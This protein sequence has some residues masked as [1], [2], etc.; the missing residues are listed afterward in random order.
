[1]SYFKNWV[2]KYREQLN[3]LLQ[4][5]LFIL[6][7]IAT[8]LAGAEW[9]FGYSLYNTNVEYTWEM[10]CSGLPF[11]ISFLSILT[12]HE[13]GHYFVAKFYRVKTSLPYYIPL[14]PF[15][16]SLGTMGAIIRLRQRV[17]TNIQNFDIGIAGPLAGFV[18]AIG[19]LWYG[20]T[21][22][23]DASYI[24]SIHPEYAIYGSDFAKHVYENNPEAVMIKVG[25]NLLFYFFKHFVAD[26][27]SLPNSYEIMHYPLL[28]AG[29]L[30]LVFT[31]LN[32]LPIGQLDGGHVLYGL[33]GFKRHKT[34]ASIVYLLLLFYAG[35]G[36][37]TP[38]MPL[39]DLVLY[40]GLYVFFLYLCLQGLKLERQTTIM[41][42][43]LLFALQFLTSYLFPT[44]IGYPG[45]LLFAFF[46]GRMG[47][48]HPPSLIEIP[49]N[50]T[51]KILGWI[52]LIIFIASFTPAPL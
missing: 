24:F 20:F 30:A 31:S 39:E 21:H 2:S 42:A 3:G 41:L 7:C 34:I 18:V 19:I 45:W 15:P 16:L 9:T 17:P 4:T 26:S 46:I 32:L 35:L 44:V 5:I 37:L 14:P 43:C 36:L 52:A 22:L 28:F 13:F 23:P 11:S 33:V 49:L 12:A 8:T 1:M 29:F 38:T 6:T 27:A 10:F 40:I 50:L 48:A 47:I 25:D 51:R